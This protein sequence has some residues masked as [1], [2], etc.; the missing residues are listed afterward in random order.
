MLIEQHGYVIALYS[1]ALP[2][3]FVRR[4]HT[5]RSVLE[6]DRIAL[7]ELG[8]PPLGVAVVAR[9]LRQLSLGDFPAGVLASAA[10]LLAHYVYAGALLGSVTKL[11]RMSV[12][13]KSHLKSLVPGTLFGVLANPVQQLVEIGPQ[14]ELGK[15]GFATHLTVANGPLRSGW[16]TGTLARQWDVQGMQEVRLPADS[17]RWWGTPRLIEFAAAIR[18]SVV[19]YELVASVRR[20]TCYWCGLEFIGDQCVFCSALMARPENRTQDHGVL[21]QETPMR[22]GP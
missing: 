1:S 9:Q 10:R 11:D 18:D 4:L 17:P 2:P 14:T 5:V 13:L 21:N 15:P 6:S 22:Q 7:L 3:E 19:L 8:L 20:D 12:D 16:V